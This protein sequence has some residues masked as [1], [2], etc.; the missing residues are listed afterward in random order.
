MKEHL[1]KIDE[2][3]LNFMNHYALRID[4]QLAMI[5]ETEIYYDSPE[6]PDLFCHKHEEQVKH[7]SG[8]YHYSGY[9]VTFGRDGVYVGALVRGIQWAEDG[10]GGSA[11][12]YLYGPGRVGYNWELKKAKREIELV[13]DRSYDF[14]FH[15]PGTSY[16]YDREILKLSRV[17]LSKER[18]LNAVASRN[19]DEIVQMKEALNRKARYLRLPENFWISSFKHKPDD[20]KSVV[21]GLI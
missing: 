14:H 7:E 3:A 10:N 5:A 18:M 1:K 9:D 11:G 6:R 21:N 16:S 4:G 8:Y 2:I 17:N 12:E 15:T 19:E 13:K 20:L